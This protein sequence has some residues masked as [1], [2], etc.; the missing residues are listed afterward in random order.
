MT[1]IL[2]KIINRFVKNISQIKT[3]KKYTDLLH[4]ERVKNY[5]HVLEPAITENAKIIKKIRENGIYVSSL[6]RLNIANA[7]KMWGCCQQ[8]LPELIATLPKSNR[9]FYVCNSRQDIDRH[10][11]AFLWGLEDRLLNLVENYLELPVAYHGIYLRKDLANGVARKSRL[12][13]IDKED[14]RMFKIIIYLNDVDRNN[15]AFQYLTRW[16]SDRAE[17][18][19]NYNHEYI[20][21]RRMSQIVP[22]SRWISC[23]GEAGTVIFVDT[24]NIFHRG[25]IP[26]KSHRLTLF[27]DYTSRYPLRSYYCKPSFPVAELLKIAT[28]LPDVQKQ[29]VFWNSK[30]RRQLAKSKTRHSN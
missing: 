8:S 28:K 12:W 3:I 20:R 5:K 13:H 29:T 1:L 15:G 16:D 30:L 10:L 25:Q 9:Q 19:L 17:R 14:R 7:D 6:N 22:E 2:K 11:D 21:D 26:L 4:I 23:D 27:F 24:A 18:L